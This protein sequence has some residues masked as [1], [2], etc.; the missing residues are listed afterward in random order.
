MFGTVGP[1][2]KGVQVKIAD[3]GEIL[4]KGSNIM[5]GY[6][7]H[8]EITEEVMDNG[9]FKTGDIGM[10]VENNFL[11][12]TDRKKEMFKT[13]GGKY[14]APLPIES[15]LKESIY[16][17]NAMVIGAEQKFTGALLVPSYA[18]VKEWCRANGINYST[19][20]DIIK[21]E[22]VIDLFKDLVE[23]FNK[24]FNNVEQIK[25]F[26]LLP[27]D[28]TVESGEMTPKL[29][30]KRKVIMEKYRNVVERIYQ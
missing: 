16:I 11:K 10:M 30:L 19:D 1:L 9:W 15:K 7:K 20:A 17:D 3:D 29:S 18:N 22:R 8:P 12:I 27:H 6:Y 23:S 26:E 14:V 2:I 13:S 4:C 21:N 25:R 5:L 28:W 24:Y